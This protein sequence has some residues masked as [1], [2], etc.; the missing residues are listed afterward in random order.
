MRCLQAVQNEVVELG[1]CCLKIRPI[2]KIQKVKLLVKL[3]DEYSL[4]HADN[5]LVNI[6][7]ASKSKFQRISFVE[8]D[9][10]S[11]WASVLLAVGLVVLAAFIKHLQRV[12]E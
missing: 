8:K 11:K 1:P 7:V 10:S 9:H 12:N 3:Q 2:D 5:D 4:M 6:A